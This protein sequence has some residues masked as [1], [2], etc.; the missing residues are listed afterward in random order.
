MT[1]RLFVQK[2][3]ATTISFPSAGFSGTPTFLARTGG[4]ASF[5][6][7]PGATV[8]VASGKVNVAIPAGTYYP[9]Y[10]RLTDNANSV[11]GLI[12]WTPA[13]VDNRV[14]IGQ[15]KFDPATQ[16]ELDASDASQNAV[17]AG[18]ESTGVAATL[19]N[20]AKLRETNAQAVAAYTLAAT[21]GGKVVEVNFATAAVVTVPANAT[22]ALPVG[23]VVVLR[24]LGA[25]AVSVA[26]AAGVTIRSAGG[27]LR[28]SA[29]YA[30]A[31]LTKRATD[32]WVLAGS[33]AV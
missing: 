31:T 32:E 24:Q 22:V 7:F 1:Y 15:L 8:T 14:D 3:V 16:A 21:D 25:G 30:E 5:A 6:A 13:P 27:A 23:T 9:K 18:K 33:I 17:I 26:A 12:E 11:E 4:S 20:A 19:V 29:Q 10:F 2:N 28:L